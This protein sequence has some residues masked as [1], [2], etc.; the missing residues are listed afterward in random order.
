VGDSKVQEGQ[1]PWEIPMLALISFCFLFAHVD[2]HPLFNR[3]S[4]FHK[5][6]RLMYEKTTKQLIFSFIDWND[7]TSPPSM[8]QLGQEVS[9]EWTW[10]YCGEDAM[11]CQPF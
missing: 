9:K 7:W 5:H 11:F 10:L 2:S 3:R 1:E 8:M 4:H 6:L